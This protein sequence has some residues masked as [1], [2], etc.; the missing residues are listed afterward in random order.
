V[1]EDF[2]PDTEDYIAIDKESKDLA[3]SGYDIEGKYFQ[4]LTT[5]Q[6]HLT[7]LLEGAGFEDEELPIGKRDQSLQ[8]LR[9]RKEMEDAINE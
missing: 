1:V 8:V 9:Q 4:L 6:Y 7:N 5:A 3:Y 2:A